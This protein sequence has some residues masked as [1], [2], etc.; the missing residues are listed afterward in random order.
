MAGGRVSLTCMDKRG[1]V[2]Y[3]GSDETDELGDFYL[4]V[5]KYIN[6]KK[7]EP[8]LCSVRLV[9]SPDTVCKLLTNF[10][11]GRSGVKLNWPSH[12]SRGLIR[13]TTGPFYFTTPM[14]DEPDTTES[15]DD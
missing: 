11:G 8:T 2:I 13:Y 12:I 6:G 15:L 14:C 10:A 5:D 4:T 3:Y 1:R 9:S 7:L